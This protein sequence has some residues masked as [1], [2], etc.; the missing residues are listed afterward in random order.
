MTRTLHIAVAVLMLSMSGFVTANAGDDN[1]NHNRNRSQWTKDMLEY[2]HDF[3]AEETGM[4]Q[5]QRDKFMPIYEAMEKEIYHV[6]N[7]AHN[8]ARKVSTSKGKVSD[9]EYATAA[10][11]LSNVKVKEGE[12]EAKYYDKF[13]KILNKKQMF[14][15]KQAEVKFRRKMI[16]RK[17]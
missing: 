15:L 14:L 10:K 7:N 17:K 2:K 16:T 4:T 12:I 1:H 8:Q 9:Q 6:N 5:A 3:I 11:A 13:A